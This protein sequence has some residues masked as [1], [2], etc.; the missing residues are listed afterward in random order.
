M[1]ILNT[2]PMSLILA[3]YLACLLKL[4][5]YLSYVAFTFP[6]VITVK[7]LVI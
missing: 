1:S 6:F 4:K 3:R 5:F 2:A 7:L